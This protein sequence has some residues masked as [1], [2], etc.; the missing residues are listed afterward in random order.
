[1][2]H[3][4][5]QNEQESE[6]KSVENALFDRIVWTIIDSFYQIVYYFRH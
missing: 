1:M 4:H 3:K 6:A 5:N 2:S